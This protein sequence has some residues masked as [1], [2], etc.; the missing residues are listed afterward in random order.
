MWGLKLFAID[1]V[2]GHQKYGYAN[3]IL[4]LVWQKQKNNDIW[5]DIIRRCMHM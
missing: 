1:V 3:Q 2:E 5:G 4:K